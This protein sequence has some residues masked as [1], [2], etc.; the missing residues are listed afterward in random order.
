MNRRIIN[1][2]CLALLLFLI[3][4]YSIEAGTLP[5]NASDS[6]R[7]KKEEVLCRQIQD[8]ITNKQEIRN[9][10]KTGIQMGYGA[11]GV[12][13]CAIKGGGDSKQVIEGA[14]EAGAAKDVI[15]RCALDAGVDARDVAFILSYID[16][17]GICY[18]LLEEPEYII[19]PGPDPSKRR[20]VISPSGF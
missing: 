13:K 15:S 19:P 8:K 20:I 10:V 11:C 16:V 4:P 14:V 3:L 1:I 18:I 17:P 5:V 9:I 2:N 6:A 12:I 7:Q